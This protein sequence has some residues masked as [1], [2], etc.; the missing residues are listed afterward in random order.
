MR[1]VAVVEIDILP[2]QGSG[3]RD[4]AVCLEVDLL[5]LDTLSQLLDEHVDTPDAL[6]VHTDADAVLSGLPGERPTVYWLPGRC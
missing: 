6:S 3:L 2:D 5:V 1:P 4:R